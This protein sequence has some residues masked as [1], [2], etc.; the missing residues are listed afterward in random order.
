MAQYYGRITGWGKYTPRRVVTNAD[1][2]Q[3]GLDTSDEWIRTRTGI[4][5]RRVAS[6]DEPNSLISVYAA[7]DA[8]TVAGVSAD[9]VDLIILASSSPDYLLPPV[10]SQVQDM[11]GANCGAFTLV[12]GCTG[13]L[14]SL[15]T[16]QQF[17]QSGA[18]KTILVIGTEIITRHVD[19]T[20]RSTCVLFGDG[21]GAVVMQRSETPTG[22]LAF[23]L[24][25]DGSGARHLWVP[26]GGTVKPMSHEVINLRENYIRMNGH[27][28][29][30]FAARMLGRSLQRTLA[31]AGLSPDDIDLFIPHQ[32]NYRIVEAA[33]RLMRVPQEKFYLN[34]HRYG[35]TSAASIPIA[36]VEALE[37]G[38]CKP[39]DTLAFV[40]FGA[41]LT[42][43][44]AVVH[45]GG[46]DPNVAHRRGRQFFLLD[47]AKYLTR[48]AAG[49]VQG[50]AVDA[51]IAL[52]EMKLNGRKARKGREEEPAHS[53]NGS[54]TNGQN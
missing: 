12:A 51:M 38:R 24:G 15:A 27:E 17:I 46:P 18:Y 26:G 33:A 22:V 2:E 49:A 39:G 31:E 29:F 37:E 7:R 44:S 36:L 4:S 30:K 14:Y 48:R 28:V 20:D 25:S 41:G 43:G 50:V 47:R 21:S 5:E 3:M 6:D 19:W 53:G 23:E 42:W 45:L 10:S 52:N 34:I 32:A 9:D 16:A 11:L 54:R 40:A 1:I 13:W 8:M 35:N